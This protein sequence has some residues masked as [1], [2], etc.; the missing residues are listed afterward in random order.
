[1][2]ILFNSKMFNKFLNT[3]SN[4]GPGALIAAAFIGPGTVTICSISGTNFGYTL[5]WVIF[6]SL[7]IVMILQEMSVRI[8]IISQKSLTEL[9]KTE[10][11]NSFLKKLL[12]VLIFIAIIIGNTAYEAGNISGAILGFEAIIGTF[13]YNLNNININLISP[14]IGLLGFIILYKGSYKLLEKTLIFFVFLMS[15]SFIISAIITKPELN[16]IINGIIQLRAPN[17]SFLT[18]LSLIGTTVVPYNIFL[19]SSLV[20]EKWKKKTDLTI[21]KIDLFI[22]VILGGIVSISIIITGANVSLLNIS[23]AADLALGLEPLY[24]PASKYFMGIGLIAAGITSSI[25]APL[26]A[27]FVAC[28]CFGWKSDFKSRKFKFIWITI[29]II[30]TIISST[31]I[32]LII[33]IE[34]A[35]ITNALLLPIIVIVLYYI[36][37][38]NKVFGSYT[39]SVYQNFIGFLIIVITIFL[40][41]K[42]ILTLFN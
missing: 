23:N 20:K 26:A 1:M 4:M 10:L 30:G 33:I 6:L 2:K 8:G 19:H 24:G 39:N 41:I 38:N 12:I 11:D 15:L 32:D 14:F 9:I 27:S 22:A 29:L 7:I 28:G 35:Q 3:I 42:T 40:S 34:F 37:N 5:L 16:N 25:T 18:I 21:A 36:M 31:G 17:N 13:S